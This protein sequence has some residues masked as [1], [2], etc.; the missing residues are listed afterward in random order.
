MN[1]TGIQPEKIALYRLE[2]LVLSPGILKQKSLAINALSNAEWDTFL[3]I[4]EFDCK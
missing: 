2:V 4:R 3:V 1:M